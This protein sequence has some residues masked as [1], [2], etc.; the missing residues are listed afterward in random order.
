MPGVFD[1]LADD[2]PKRD[3]GPS[4]VD[5]TG[6][7]PSLRRVMRLIMRSG[8]CSQADL[9]QRR[10]EEPEGERLSEA[11]LERALQTLLAEGWILQTGQ[12][13]PATFRINLARRRGHVLDPGAEPAEPAPARRRSV[14]MKGLWDKL[15][16]ERRGDS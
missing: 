3:P 1:R 10:E 11:D 4:V 8:E 9:L 5:L 7:A 14:T 2:A 12:G 15:D 6:L 13:E 16:D